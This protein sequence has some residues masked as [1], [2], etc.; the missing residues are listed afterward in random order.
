MAFCRIL[1]WDMWAITGRAR[2]SVGASWIPTGTGSAEGK[3]EA[4][5]KALLPRKWLCTFWKKGRVGG[6][7]SVTRHRVIELRVQM[8]PGHRMY[9]P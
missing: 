1:S 4:D 8:T 6:S 7:V 2:V 9:C 3:A 5:W